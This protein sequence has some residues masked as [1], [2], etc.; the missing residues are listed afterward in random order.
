M[1]GDIYCL[2]GAGLALLALWIMLG[3]IRSTPRTRIFRGWRDVI[4]AWRKTRGLVERCLFFGL[5]GKYLFG[6]IAAAVIIPI[7][8]A[9]LTIGTSLCGLNP[10]ALRVLRE[11]VNDIL[12]FFDSLR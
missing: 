9:A 7:V 12:D 11:I 8:C 3:L 4:R 10:D 1:A 2:L 6:G 5:L